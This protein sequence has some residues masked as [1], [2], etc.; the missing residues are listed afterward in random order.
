MVVVPAWA[1]LLRTEAQLAAIDRT[2]A[3]IEDRRQGSVVGIIGSS[4]AA[5]VLRRA[6]SV[7]PALPDEEP[8]SEIER[9]D[10]ARHDLDPELL[11]P[12][13]LVAGVEEEVEHRD[14]ADEGHARLAV[15]EVHDLDSREALPV[16]ELFSAAAPR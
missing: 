2:A 14:L 1:G 9:V 10:D 8:G 5:S 6:R 4:S 16:H 3:T 11:V 7:K 12:D 13:G 15:D